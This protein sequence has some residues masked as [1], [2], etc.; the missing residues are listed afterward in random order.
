[1]ANPTRYA[2]V[3]CMLLR[4]GQSNDPLGHPPMWAQ[5]NRPGLS[6]SSM[7]VCIIRRLLGVSPG[8][9][10]TDPCCD[11]CL[12]DAPA[13]STTP[14]GR[15]AAAMV[16]SCLF[17][18]ID[19][20]VAAHCGPPVFN[21]IL[22][23][24]H[25]SPASVPELLPICAV[26]LRTNAA[27]VLG[28]SSLSFDFNL[29]AICELLCSAGSRPAQCEALASMLEVLAE[30]IPL[31]MGLPLDTANAQFSGA[32]GA[33]IQQNIVDATACTAQML[34]S[35]IGAAQRRSRKR[36][37]AALDQQKAGSIA[38]MTAD[39]TA[40]LDQAVVQGAG[41]LLERLQLVGDAPGTQGS[42]LGAGSFHTTSQLLVKMPLLEAEHFLL[43]LRTLARQH[44]S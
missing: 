3:F 18:L 30:I 19:S 12:P 39:I 42:G 6:H 2:S 4:G 38:D 22:E 25:T 32:F 28:L 44:R 33:N 15:K 16:A 13:G 5:S 23:A 24:A 11:P 37:Q 20:A 35:A 17:G 31:V 21:A 40:H 8:A 14:D 27:V 36:K 29:R 34:S 9:W 26:V 43:Q 7:A 41:R 1:L 10:L